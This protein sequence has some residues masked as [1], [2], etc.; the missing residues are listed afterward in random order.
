[1]D[2]LVIGLRIVHILSAILWVGGSAF[3]FFY[4]EPTMTKLGPDAEKFVD[5]VMNKRKAPIYFMV[6]S[7]LAVLGGAVLYWRDSSGLSLD[8][9]T[10]PTGLAF[11][12]GAIGAIAAWLGGNLLIPSTVMK[13]SGVGAQLKAAGGPPSPDLVSRLHAF[14]ER[15][16]TIGLV[17]IVLLA[18]AI[19]GMASARYLG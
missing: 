13:L 18:I 3:F 10:S 4:L 16:H 9:I 1:L 2:I 8:W 5:E 14:Q 7:T 6:F 12:I 17:D 19:V 15:L 11:T